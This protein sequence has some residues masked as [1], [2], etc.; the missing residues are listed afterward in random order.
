MSSTYDRT[1]KRNRFDNFD[2]DNR[3]YMDNSRDSRSSRSSRHYSNHNEMEKRE[4]TP[5]SLKLPKGWAT[6][7]KPIGNVIEGTQFLPFKTP[8]HHTY[9]TL[10]VNR[11]PL[12]EAFRPED[13]IEHCRRKNIKLGL[14]IDLTSTNRYYDKYEFIK[15]KISYFKLPCAGHEIHED[16]PKTEKFIEVVN[17]FLNDQRNV[18]KIIGVHCT[19]GL[20][21]TGYMICRYMTDILGFSA[22][23][24]T[25]AFEKA[26]GYEMVRIHYK[27]HLQMLENQRNDKHEYYKKRDTDDSDIIECRDDL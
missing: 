22:K 19:H 26:R 11:V 7:K 20:N 2:K 16:E 6:Y 9:F 23:N 3:R 21:R 15:K 18:G 1:R 14:I 5:T 12:K 10:H 8:L 4:F 27:E 13:L 24:A 25:D 17:N